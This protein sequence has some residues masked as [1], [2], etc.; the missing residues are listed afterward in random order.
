MSTVD[1]LKEE[2]ETKDQIDDL[3]RFLRE[4]GVHIKEELMDGS[5]IDERKNMSS[6]FE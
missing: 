5:Q 1:E 2:T 3:E 4:Q 6:V